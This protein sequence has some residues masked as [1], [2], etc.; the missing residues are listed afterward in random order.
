MYFKKLELV[1]FKSFCDNALCNLHIKVTGDNDH[2]KLESIFKAVARAIN[3]AITKNKNHELPSTK[4][5][6]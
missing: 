2:H 6:L 3:D 1:G 4:G 5:I